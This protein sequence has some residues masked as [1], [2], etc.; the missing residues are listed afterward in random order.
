MSSARLESASA[1]TA[2]AET[3]SAETAS[4]ETEANRAS[5]PGTEQLGESFRA[6]L[7]A[8][9]RLRARET[10]HPGELS[11]AQYGLLFG[12]REHEPM[13]S[14]ELA[15]TAELSPASATEMLDGLVSAGLVRRARSERDRRIV[16]I[17]LTERGGALVEARR[18][19]YE[20][21]WR[22][23]LAEFTDGELR[24]AAAVLDRIRVLFDEM[25]S[26]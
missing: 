10:R 25:G 1:E 24:T 14:S 8:V 13:S 18:A 12:L 26:E 2:S 20:P 4:A 11:Y 6:A 23:T 21:R 16:L 3:A 19:M 17:S 15:L 7:A 22:K 5:R 9:R